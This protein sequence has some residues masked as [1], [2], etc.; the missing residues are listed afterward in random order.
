MVTCSPS[1]FFTSAP[2]TRK[3]KIYTVYAKFSALARFF[4]KKYNINILYDALIIKY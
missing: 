2:R 1:V 3:D 4:V